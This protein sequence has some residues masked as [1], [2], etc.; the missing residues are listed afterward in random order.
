M[1]DEE[2]ACTHMLDT[3]LSLVRSML[4][5]STLFEWI[6]FAK[7]SRGR[8]WPYARYCCFCPMTAFA[9]THNE[10]AAVGMDAGAG[11]GAMFWAR[12]WDLLMAQ[13]DHG[14]L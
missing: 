14:T 5:P 13:T 6:L 12:A 2:M 9:P 3:Y 1:N 4:G 10:K 7:A 11:C 8:C